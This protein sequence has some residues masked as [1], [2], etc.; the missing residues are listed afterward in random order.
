MRRCAC[1][2]WQRGRERLTGKVRPTASGATGLIS[3]KIHV[4]RPYH[5]ESAG[6]GA[7]AVGL[8]IWLHARNYIM[9]LCINYV[10]SRLQTRVH[11][12]LQRSTC[13][14][15]VLDDYDDDDD[16][17][18][19]NYACLG[20]LSFSIFVHWPVLLQTSFRNW[21]WTSD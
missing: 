12:I 16:V 11:I 8:A 2:I 21:I 6:T 13:V 5:K 4:Q 14:V 19:E 10:S 15:M 7:G 18:S 9:Y 20:L 3:N 1:G 17:D